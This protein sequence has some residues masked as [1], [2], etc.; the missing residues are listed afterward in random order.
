MSKSPHPRR[1][2]STVN[3]HAAGTHT[4]PAA[5]ASK[6]QATAESASVDLAKPLR[7]R[8]TPG[9]VTFLLIGP[10]G[11]IAATAPDEPWWGRILYAVFGVAAFLFGRYGWVRAW[12][13]RILVVD[14]AEVRVRL[15]RR[16]LFDFAWQDLA[17]VDVVQRPGGYSLY[18]PPMMWL[19]SI[20]DRT[21][22]PG[23][24]SRRARANGT[25]PGRPTV[26]SW[27]PSARSCR[28]WTRH[29]AQCGQNTTVACGNSPGPIHP[30][31][32]TAF[33]DLFLLR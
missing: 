8:V 11:L 16:C 33:A 10:L 6:P 22:P 5:A 25:R 26:S 3:G 28:R 17:F 29:S 15:R 7:L 12:G 24:P 27:A 1:R 31:P 32:G 19:T 14:G 20:P 13:T 18:L 9:A 2:T 23:T 21:S 30:N 4:A